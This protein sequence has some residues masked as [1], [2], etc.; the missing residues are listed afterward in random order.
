MVKKYQKY[1][2]I[3][4]AIL[5]VLSC[6]Q[7]D[8]TSNLFASFALSSDYVG[9]SVMVDSE[10]YNMNREY[11]Q[12][13]PQDYWSNNNST[14]VSVSLFKCS[15]GS[16]RS[17]GR[18]E[19]MIAILDVVSKVVLYSFIMILFA[20]GA[21]RLSMPFQCLLYYIQSMDGKKRIA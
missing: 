5:M 11:S 6:V 3:W 15:Q 17:H 21:T 10:S 13:E 7:I 4:F 9:T 20:T 14:R 18:S 2:I 19:I 1:I 16:Y 8:N 12:V